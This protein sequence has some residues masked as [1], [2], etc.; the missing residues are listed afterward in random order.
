MQRKLN[1]QNYGSNHAQING[2]NILRND[3][4]ESVCPPDESPYERNKNTQKQHSNNH[5]YTT[6]NGVIANNANNGGLNNNNSRLLKRAGSVP[7]NLSD[8]SGKCSVLL[9]FLPACTPIIY[10]IFLSKH[11]F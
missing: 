4:Y 8:D 9:L 7:M 6:N 2:N 1:D 10:V 11:L 5:P 3:T